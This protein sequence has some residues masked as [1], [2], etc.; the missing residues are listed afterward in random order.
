MGCLCIYIWHAW[1]YSPDIITCRCRLLTPRS[2]S[3]DSSFRKGD[4]RCL[5][6]CSNSIM[7]SAC[8][9]YVMMDICIKCTLCL[10]CLPPP[11]REHAMLTLWNEVKLC[12]RSWYKFFIYVSEKK[13]YVRTYTYII[14][15]LHNN[16]Q[17]TI[18]KLK[19]ASC[20]KVLFGGLADFGLFIAKVM[21]G[22]KETLRL[23]PA[24]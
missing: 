9:Q 10:S 7:S 17:K 20:Q 21:E 8:L 11:F 1:K 5:W 24:S 12:K 18:F 15:M 23:S 22:R 4:V 13:K 14:N 6:L 16:D 3:V 2:I 19:W